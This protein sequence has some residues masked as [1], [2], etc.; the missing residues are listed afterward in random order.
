[1]HVTLQQWLAARRSRFWHEKGALDLLVDATEQGSLPMSGFVLRSRLSRRPSTPRTDDEAPPGGPA[2]RTPR[3]VPAEPWADGVPALIFQT[4]KV[5]QPLPA[6][7]RYWSSTLSAHNPRRAHIV[8]DDQDNRDFIASDFPWFL[9]CYD[10]YPREIYR[11]DIVRLFFLYRF[12]GLYADMDTECLCPVDKALGAGDVILGAMGPDRACIYSIP[13]AVMAAKPRQ[14]FWL[15]AI[16]NAIDRAA[17]CAK[18]ADFIA[19]GP[20]YLTGAVLL[21]D[22]LL[23]YEAH[24]AEEVR[25]HVARSLPPAVAVAD[26][27]AGRV[28]VLPP[29]TWYPI[30]WNNLWHQRFRR[31]LLRRRTPLTP[32]EV[33]ALFPA[34]HMVSYWTHAW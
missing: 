6:N 27:A 31:E 16:A 9:P 34:A 22:S 23:Q 21:R 26:A 8:W 30:N 11:V 19:R 18:T 5:R 33:R 4:W 17:L 32:G 10:R 12:G 28:A 24:G 25:Q 3:I 20:E 1:M 13:N 29:A 7:Y 2:A 14:L 15:L